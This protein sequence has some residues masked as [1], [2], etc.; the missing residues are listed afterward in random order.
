[1]TCLP[2]KLQHSFPG[3]APRDPFCSPP[4]PTSLP[5]P[6]YALPPTPGEIPFLP[7]STQQSENQTSG[8][9]VQTNQL[10][11]EVQSTEF[12][13]N[14]PCQSEEQRQHPPPFPSFT[15]DQ[16]HL[17]QHPTR[18]ALHTRSEVTPDS[19]NSGQKDYKTKQETETKRGEG[20]HQYNKDK[21]RS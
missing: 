9:Q 4:P 2:N 21:L 6:C 5:A 17:Q 3:S 1:M 19:R 18:T 10:G 13:Q 8:T 15:K 20:G 11:K 7:C 12:S 16:T 14:R